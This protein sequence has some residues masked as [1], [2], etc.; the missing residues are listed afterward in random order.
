MS[1]TTTTTTLSSHRIGSRASET[2]NN[3]AA[4]LESSVLRSL[5]ELR[6]NNTVVENDN[7]T[8][9]NCQWSPRIL[10]SLRKLFV[11]DGRKFSS[12]K[13]F[14][15]DTATTTTTT[16]ELLFAEILEMIL[17]NNSTTA[18]VVKGGTLIGNSSHQQQQ[19][20]SCGSSSDA[21]CS[22]TASVTTALQ[23][24][25]SNNKNNSLKSLTLSGLDFS[26]HSAVKSLVEALSRNNTLESI[27]LRQSSLDDQSIAQLLRSVESHSSLSSLDLSRNYLGARRRSNADSSSAL[28]A[29]AELL[30]SNDSKLESLNLSHQYQEHT[31]TTSPLSQHEIQQHNIAFGT[32]M[33]ALST[34]QSLRSIDL[35]CNPGCL[36]DP[37]SVKALADCLSANTSL[38]HANLSGCGMTSESIAYLANECFPV[39]GTSLKSLVL[40][41]SSSNDDN[42]DCYRASASALEKGLSSNATLEDLGDLPIGS[43]VQQILNQNKGGR[44]VFQQQ[45]P[46]AAW[47]HLLARATNLEYNNDNSSN[48]NATSV[49]FSLLRQGSILMER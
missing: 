31:I 35:S 20:S 2:N 1:Y 25:L 6:K 43:S 29:V 15:C 3:Y 14:D 45:V 34:N 16:S 9:W 38:E 46:I 8:F 28:D 23:E 49:V 39:C 4:T 19:S 12:I 10:Q 36:S 24:G 47:S 22:T 48:N 7:L 33:E 37:S 21:S 26:T 18:L 13:F 11:R 41:G 32:A 27:N 17:T 42:V 44:R 40:F 5:F 30:R